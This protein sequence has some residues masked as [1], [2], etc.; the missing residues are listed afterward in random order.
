MSEQ[1]TIELLEGVM[2]E[3][4]GGVPARQQ[5]PPLT[6]SER[7]T[8]ELCEASISA[9]FETQAAAILAVRTIRDQKLW[10]ADY[11]NWD[12][13]CRRRWQKS[14]HRINELIRA[15]A[16]IETL[17]DDQETHVSPALL[18]SAD[19]ET[20]VS[21]ECPLPNPKQA[22]E[23]SKLDEPEEQR[24]VWAEI[25]SSG[26]P[27]TAA[28]VEEAVEARKAEKEYPSLSVS[29]W[30][31]KEV[32][33]AKRC[34]DALPPENREAAAAMIGQTGIPAERALT[35]LENLAAMEPERREETLRLYH[36]KDE[37]DQSAAIGR[38]VRQRPAADPR[39]VTYLGMLPEME[40]CARM[41]PGDPLQS[42]YEEIVALTRQVLEETLHQEESRFDGTV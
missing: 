31:S 37:R 34:L 13:Y 1:V 21:S 23:L 17:T 8:F 4:N 10:R 35:A 22:V 39:R 36:S 25:V 2:P 7:Q 26:E 3:R 12:D 11:E 16:V 5:A 29:G 42:R 9:G 40:H 14:S 24:E 28:K 18:E 27:V 6:Q 38:M 30:S 20:H 33:K 32:V 41:F 19:A 15:A